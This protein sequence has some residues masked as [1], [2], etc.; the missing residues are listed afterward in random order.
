MSLFNLNPQ[1]IKFEIEG[2]PLV[3]RAFT[4]KDYLE[5]QKIC[6][7]EEKYKKAWTEYLMDL[8]MRMAWDQLDFKSQKLVI[9]AVTG[10]YI[11]PDTGEIMEKKLTPLEKFNALC[12]SPDEQLL[13]ITSLIKCMGLNMPDLNDQESLKKWSDQLDKDMKIME[14]MMEEP[15]GQ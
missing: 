12:A 11:D 13:I 9:N 1:K 7:G 14:K 5:H 8:I 2:I 4:I 6:G 15:T 3:F 10:E